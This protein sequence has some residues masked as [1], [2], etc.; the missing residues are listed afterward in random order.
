MCVHQ[1]CASPKGWE[2]SESAN[3]R[4]ASSYLV[5]KTHEFITM[6]VAA[7]LHCY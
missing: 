5:E 1:A 6:D 2:L 4:D 7:L 3:C